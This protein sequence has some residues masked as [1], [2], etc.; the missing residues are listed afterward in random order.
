MTTPNDQFRTADPD[1]ATTDPRN[2]AIQEQVRAD[3]DSL[4]ESSRRVEAS[5]RDDGGAATDREAAAKQ[6]R[7]RADHDR[8]EESARRVE[9]SVP[10]DVRNTPVQPARDDDDR[11]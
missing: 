5:V 8:L 1:S 6:D 7:V 4:K 10:S 2:A 9:A 3:H 11:R